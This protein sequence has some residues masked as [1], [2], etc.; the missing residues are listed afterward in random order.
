[1][2]DTVPPVAVKLA[3]VAP[4]ATVTDAGTVMAALFE[5]SVTKEPPAGAVCATVT[6]QV[7]VAPDAMLVGEQDNAET[8]CATVIVPPV[9][10]VVVHVPSGKADIT[11]LTGSETTGL[12]LEVNVAETVATMPLPIA[13]PFN[14]LT[15]HVTEPLAGLQFR[16]LPAD[17]NAVP[18]V[19]VRDAIFV[20]EYGIDH[21]KLAGALPDEVNDRF[22]VTEPPG[23]DK[24]DP[25]VREF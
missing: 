22:N 12:L 19:V 13:V 6:V 9:P 11:L 16:V 3:V 10:V 20:G 5:D 23:T 8:D 17:V 7:E 1:L 14:P 15:T 18:A 21:C 25:S 4:D 24:P 2:L